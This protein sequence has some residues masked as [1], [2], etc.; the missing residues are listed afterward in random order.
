MM[1]TDTPMLEARNITKSFGNIQAIRNISL[2]L[3]QRARCWGYWA[4]TVRAN[5]R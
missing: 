2:T 4:I 3:R 1:N 5:P